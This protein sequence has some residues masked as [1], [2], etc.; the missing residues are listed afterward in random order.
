M[1]LLRNSWLLFVRSFKETIRTPVWVFVGLMQPVFFLTLFG[2]IF[3][4]VANGPGFPNDSAMNV[5]IPGL[6]IQL[7]LF[8]AFAGFGLIDEMRSGVIER[9]RVTPVSRFALLLGRAARDIL[10]V[11]VQATILVL[12]AIPFGLDFDLGGFLVTLGLLVFIGLAL[13]SVS[14]AL[15]TRL[16]SEDALAPVLNMVSFPLLLLSGIILPM[17][18]APGWLRRIADFN[19]FGYAV[20]A[21]RDLFNG[22]TGDADVFQ[23]LVIFVVLSALTVWWA[24]RSFRQAT[25]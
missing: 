18:L 14:Y 13:A 1:K 2:P 3:K 20:D 5:F 15:A 17:S 19:P 9:F 24:A 25:A 22:R 10:I 4:N 12:L 21:S 23:A 7:T 6:L 11:L 8:T 16:K